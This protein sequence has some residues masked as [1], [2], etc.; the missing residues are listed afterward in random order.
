MTIESLKNSHVIRDSLSEHPRYNE[1]VRI[2]SNL[3]EWVDKLDVKCWVCHEIIQDI[4]IPIIISWPSKDVKGVACSF[5][6]AKRYLL[7][8][9]DPDIDEQNIHLHID[10]LYK[11][12]SFLGLIEKNEYI[13][14]SCHF[15]EKK[16]Y[17]YK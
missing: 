16:G 3:L 13:D 14:P 9:R 2:P 5:A 6:E 10:N 12:C 8:Y 17:G 15:Y 7:S 11:G 4:P 1:N